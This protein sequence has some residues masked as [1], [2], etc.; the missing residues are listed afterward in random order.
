MRLENPCSCTGSKL[1]LQSGA[2]DGGSCYNPKYKKAP[3]VQGHPPG[4][5]AQR[6]LKVVNPSVA[7]IATPG[8][9]FEFGINQTS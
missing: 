4:D 3:G 7:V 2:G 1:A 8:S 9:Y 6:L 5:L